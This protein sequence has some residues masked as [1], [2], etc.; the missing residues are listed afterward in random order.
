MLVDSKLVAPHCFPTGHAGHGSGGQRGHHWDR[1]RTVELTSLGANGVFSGQGVGV[2]SIRRELDPAL[3]ARCV[4]L[5]MEVANGTNTY[6]S[7]VEACRTL[8]ATTISAPN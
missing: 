5:S 8:W 6:L 2:S 4:E 1:R 3:A 7:Q